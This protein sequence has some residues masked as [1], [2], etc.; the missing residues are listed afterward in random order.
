[1][2]RAAR[3]SRC[4]LPFPQD[5][6]DGVKVKICGVNDEAAFDAALG[7]GADWIGFVFFPPSPRFVTP[8]RAAELSARGGGPLRVGLFVDPA[9]ADIEAVLQEIH[10]DALQL[11]VS[12]ARAAELRRRFDIPVWRGVGI[13]ARG[14]LPGPEPEIDAFLIEAKAPPGATR[15]GGNAVSFEWGLTAGWHAPLP[16]LLA[17]GLTPENVA[18]AIGASGAPAVD[19]S[20]GVERSKGVKDPDR[21]AAFVAA[22]KRVRGHATRTARSGVG[23][24]Q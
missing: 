15:P 2:S 20:S 3:A 23:S 22:A 5:G 24:A 8:T 19:V 12:P 21:I 17:G 7:A 14:D 11:Y 1:M 13:G 6:G 16:W 9:E 10:L 18:A 4:D